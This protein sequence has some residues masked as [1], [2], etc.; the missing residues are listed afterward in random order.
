MGSMDNLGDAIYDVA[1][2]TGPRETDS[3]ARQVTSTADQL[4]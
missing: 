3:D 4:E 2:I 1:G